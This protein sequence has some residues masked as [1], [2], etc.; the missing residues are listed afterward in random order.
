MSTN[1]KQTVFP[2]YNLVKLNSSSPDALAIACGGGGDAL[3]G[4]K[5][6]LI[7]FSG[8]EEMAFVECRQM[9]R[10]IQVISPEHS[11]QVQAIK[12]TDQLHRIALLPCLD[13][14]NIE[15]YQKLKMENRTISTS[16][17]ND[18][19]ISKCSRLGNETTDEFAQENDKK[20]DGNPNEPD[21]K[22]LMKSDDDASSIKNDKKSDN[23]N[24]KGLDD[25]IVTLS[26]RNNRE[27]DDYNTTSRGKTDKCSP[28]LSRSS[29]SKQ[30][31]KK[32]KKMR[33]TKINQEIYKPLPCV[34]VVIIY[35]SGHSM[36][37]LMEDSFCFI[38]ESGI[39]L[40][41]FTVLDNKM[42]IWDDEGLYYRSLKDIFENCPLQRPIGVSKGSEKSDLI[43]GIFKK[44]NQFY[45][46]LKVSNMKDLFFE[47]SLIHVLKKPDEDI[48]KEDGGLRQSQIS[49]SWGGKEIF[50]PDFE[51]VSY[52]ISNNVV[53]LQGKSVILWMEA[54]DQ[55]N[56]G[57]RVLLGKKFMNIPITSI[58]PDFKL[59]KLYL[60]LANGQIG[61]ITINNCISILNILFNPFLLL[62]TRSENPQSTSSELKMVLKHTEMLLPITGI[63]THNG[64]VLFCGLNG[65]V[66]QI[67]DRKWK[68]LVMAI[69]LG[70]MAIICFI[71]MRI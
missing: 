13:L 65:C 71:K 14:K 42:I 16:K 8:A 50:L 7:I 67:G 46:D 38:Y 31:L 21:E 25:K 49:L 68:Y 4:K 3:F 34:L 22:N 43:F 53:V 24:P 18:E 15:F 23:V 36:L 33:F 47:G 6:G 35:S 45:T 55:K 63:I 59:R 19:A 32:Y 1:Y 26:R 5:N 37:L 54:I 66:G 2:L 56:G 9:V 48:I 52:F 41:K 64:H 12:E 58:Y 40:R 44:G 51:L 30:F 20:S 70:L 28:T 11:G 27:L 62:K 17:Q 10:D 69:I 61:I 57:H 39:S 29:P 60:G